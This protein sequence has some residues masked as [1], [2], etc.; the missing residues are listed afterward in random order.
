MYVCWLAQLGLREFSR[1]DDSSNYEDEEDGIPKYMLCLYRHVGLLESF[2][3]L[4]G[5]REQGDG[6]DSDEEGEETLIH[7]EERVGSAEDLHEAE[8]NKQ[9]LEDKDENAIVIARNNM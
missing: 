9:H 3:V 8:Y 2:H 7:E 1:D 6:G 5:E 4:E